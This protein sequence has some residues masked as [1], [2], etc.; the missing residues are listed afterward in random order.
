VVVEAFVVN[1]R[2]AAAADEGGLVQLLLKR[3]QSGGVH[4]SVFGLPALQVRRL[5]CCAAQLAA[6]AIGVG[7]SWR[8]LREDGAGRGGVQ[9]PRCLGQTGDRLLQCRLC[10]SSSGTALHAQRSSWSC[11]SS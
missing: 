7:A 11:A 1:I 9:R 4:Y 10:C 3:W 2:D 5:A 8:G 6:A